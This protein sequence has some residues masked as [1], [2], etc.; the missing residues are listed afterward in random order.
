MPA[1]LI[2]R[3]MSG[4]SS[5]N[6]SNSAPLT[7]ELVALRPPD[8]DHRIVFGE[9][10]PQKLD[11]I[12]ERVHGLSLRIKVVGRLERSLEHVAKRVVVELAAAWTPL[13]HATSLW[14]AASS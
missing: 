10:T 11:A 12:V 7:G 4:G 3:R 5:S 2:T 9:A 13:H 6:S 8:R 1:K 14:D